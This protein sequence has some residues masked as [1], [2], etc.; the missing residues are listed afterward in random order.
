MSFWAGS[1]FVFPPLSVKNAIYANEN[2]VQKGGGGVRVRIGAVSPKEL[3][4]LVLLLLLSP[5][6]SIDQ[7]SCGVYCVSF[8]IFVFS[9][10]RLN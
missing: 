2:Q 10:D 5:F 3:V 4:L 1:V 9:G 6:F 8:V 7:S